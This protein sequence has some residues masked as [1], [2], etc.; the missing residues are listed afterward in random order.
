MRAKAR[1]TPHEGGCVT[2]CQEVGPHI[3]HRVPPAVGAV[4]APLYRA[5]RHRLT[6]RE[7]AERCVV[8]NSMRTRRAG[9]PQT[10]PLSHFPVDAG[11]LLSNSAA[12]GSAR[13]W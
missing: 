13:R 10:S 8:P 6:A 7:S 11:R 2:H 5:D 3:I 12:A 9:G 1:I 4:D